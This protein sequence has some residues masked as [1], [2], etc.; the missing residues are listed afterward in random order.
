MGFGTIDP[1]LRSILQ[2]LATV[3]AQITCAGKIK[4][5]RKQDGAPQVGFRAPGLTVTA[6]NAARVDSFSKR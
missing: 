3:A 4:D 5:G 6:R 1:V 2:T